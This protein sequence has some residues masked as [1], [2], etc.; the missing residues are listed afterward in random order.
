MGLREEEMRK[1]RI[2]SVP[3]A[4]LTFCSDS[5][6]VLLVLINSTLDIML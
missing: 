1:Q 3:K 4:K 2:R 6:K 5:V